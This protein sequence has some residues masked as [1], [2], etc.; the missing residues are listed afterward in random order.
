M[1]ESPRFLE[2]AWKTNKFGALEQK[3]G[4]LQVRGGWHVG[5][6]INPQEEK[7]QPSVPLPAEIRRDIQP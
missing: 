1:P 5:W 6:E 4:C 7:A 2:V 3:E